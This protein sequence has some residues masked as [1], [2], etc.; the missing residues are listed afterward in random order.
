MPF[1]NPKGNIL[2]VK[3][4][5]NELARC[6][7]KSKKK[8]RLLSYSRNKFNGINAVSIKI[9]RLPVF[10]GLFNTFKLPLLIPNNVLKTVDIDEGA[11][12]G[13]ENSDEKSKI[14]KVW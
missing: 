13:D 7:G 1:K 6:L 10:K 9:E 4:C 11:D 2:T 5:N 14:S 8:S 12:K 3:T